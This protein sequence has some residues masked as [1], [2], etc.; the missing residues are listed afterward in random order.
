MRI[1]LMMR[2][3][4]HFKNLDRKEREMKARESL[5]REESSDSIKSAHCPMASFR[6]R[7]EQGK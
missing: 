7:F 5:Q 1:I 6:S 3:Y 2:S 4:S